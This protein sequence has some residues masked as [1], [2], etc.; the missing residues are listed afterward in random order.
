MRRLIVRDRE[1]LGMV[2]ESNKKR[3]FICILYGCSVPV[4]LRKVRDEDTDEEGE[5]YV[6]GLM[7]SE[8][9]VLQREQDGESAMK[10][11]FELR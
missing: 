11:T 9:F 7:D 1:L 3:G 10:V 6:H 2:S 8:A 5:C 4:V